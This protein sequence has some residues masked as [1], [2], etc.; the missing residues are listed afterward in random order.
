M[1]GVDDAFLGVGDKPGLDIWCIV[2]SGLVP[3]AKPQH[4]KFYSRNC[5]IILNTTELKT[6]VRIHDVHY[7]VGEEAKEEDYLMAS[8]KA[9]ELDAALGSHAV[10]YRETQG[11]ESDKFLSYF[12]PCIIPVHSQSPPHMVGS[13]H[14]SSR[15]TMF[16]C[17]GEHVA[18]VKEVP[19]SRSS[20][21]HKGVFI[22]DTASKIF[23]FS[24]CNSSVQTRAKA[25]D[26]VKH[27]KENRHSGRCEI[28]AIED[29]KLVGDSDAGEFWNLFGGYAPI[30]R[31]LSEAV[32]EESMNMPSKIFFWINKRILVPME[33]HLLDR[34]ILNSDRSYILDC[35]TEI[36]LW[37]GMTTLVSERKTSVTALEDYVHS[38]G[39]SSRTVIMTEGHETVEFKLHF[40]HW[41]K[42]VGMKLYNAGREKVAAIFKHQGYDV[43]EI[44]EDKPQQLISCDGSLKVWLVD[45]GCT[46]L[47]STEEQEQLYTGD[48]YIIQYSYVED[49]KDYHLFFAWS[50]KNSVKEDSMA[51]AS[52]VSNLADSVK[53]H[54]VVAQVFEGREPELFFS[55]FK[56]LII[57][58]GGRSAA[59]RNHVLQ[60]SDRNGSHQRDG[61][62]LFRVQGLKH[63][64]M[65]A[66][67]VD[68]VA[69][70][71]NSSH[72]YI[73]QDG[74][75]YFTWLGSL[76][77]PSDH[78]I[79]DRMMN[80]LCPL[81]QS[82]LVREGSEPDDF[83]KALGGRSEYSKEKHVK[84][85][86]A[87]PHLYACR[88]EQGLLKVKEI[89]SFCQ[90]DLATEETLILDCNDE[91]YV[92]VGLHSDVT[93]KE[94]AL[95]IA[96]MFLQ[97]GIL[98]NRRSIETTVYIVTEGDEP[99]FFTNFFNW[100][101]SKQS[102]M[103]GNSF[104]RK[105]ALLKGLSPKL[106]T[107]DRSMRRPS[108]RRPGVSSEPTT[109]EQQQ[110]Q[111]SVARRA[112]GSAS[113]WRLARERSPATGLPPSP[114]LS[115]SPRSR[116]S[117]STSTPTAVARRL[118]PASL[119]ASETVHALSNGN[120]TARRR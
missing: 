114:T 51:T 64:C 26:V 9:V 11:E 37:M 105:L 49:G 56:S 24:G 8:D 52:L 90:D 45:H 40:Q 53:G 76:S 25:L 60:K 58:K 17:E 112:F 7:W 27:L 34:E 5:Y 30:P 32:S 38:Q 12:K 3:V 79:L 96:K 86:P 103:A 75:S 84:G 82:L 46:T 115:Q 71:L 4:G 120:G 80:K 43:T 61:V 91:I 1:K 15:T 69:S 113:T 98:Q 74:G 41:P 93:S 104:E 14:K 100:D 57:F 97:D 101:S 39:R 94:Q 18:R 102:S 83:W 117:S 89:F 87:D 107:P 65:Q 42:I 50:G 108:T 47:L 77:L 29:G 78:N 118:F 67:Q 70:S 95:D 10:Q 23:I 13:G 72:C 36:F 48:S 20:L 62:A 21:D 63:D 116:S 19:F 16:R 55:I 92:W 119:H 33:A 44:P 88:F 54:P 109:P 31:D 2:G 106:E 110:Q 22:V 35:G 99:A 68:L 6:G 111:P 85:W 66:I 73:L 28:A 81:K 59:Y